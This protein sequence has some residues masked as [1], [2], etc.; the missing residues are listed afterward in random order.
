MG[1]SIS[2]NIIHLEHISKK[3]DNLIALNDVTVSIPAA[4][5]VGF[6]GPDGAG[7]STLMKIILTLEN[8]DS[9]AGFVFG[10]PIDEAKRT[11]RRHIGYMPEIFSLYTDL[12]VEENL[13][14]FFQIYKIPRSEYDQKMKSLYA[15]NRLDNFKATP[16]GQLSG[17]MKQ[18]LALSC[19]LMH[20]PEI[21]ILDEPT[22]GV[23]PVSRAEFWKMLAQL[24]NDGK[25]IVIS[26]PYLD[27]AMQCDYIYLFHQGKIL[28]E[29]VPD[30]IIADYETPFYLLEAAEPVK[31]LKKLQKNLSNARFFLI[32]DKIHFTIKQ[33]DEK[34]LQKISEIAGQNIAMSPITPTLEDVFLDLIE[35]SGE[36]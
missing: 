30:K 36:N 13:K 1:N 33:K 28:Q 15:F 6:I 12:S 8:P 34:S 7:K 26:T 29:G 10:E 17:G 11:I 9:G 2:E 19:A 25:T 16:A 3:F 27:E 21:L 23:D 5:I 4:S 24:K 20:D 35:N 32:G 14:F 18:K 31:T 22:T